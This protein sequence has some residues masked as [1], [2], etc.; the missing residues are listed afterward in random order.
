MSNFL[1]ENTRRVLLSEINHFVTS[2]LRSKNIDIKGLSDILKISP[3]SLYL[4]LSGHNERI[5]NSF[6]LLVQMSEALSESPV[7]F[8]EIVLRKTF[9]GTKKAF[10]NSVS[11]NETKLLSFYSLLSH[12]EKKAF[13][14]R[15]TDESNLNIFKNIFVEVANVKPKDLNVL[16]NL[17]K[18]YRLDKDFRK[19]CL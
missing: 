16:L 19:K 5:L 11:L 3:K 12:D 2:A 9:F 17:V 7:D 13:I 10:K 8:I 4:Y 1:P 14:Y 18:K 6:D 15:I